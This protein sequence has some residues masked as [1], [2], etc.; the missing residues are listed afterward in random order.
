MWLI[1]GCSMASCVNFYMSYSKR[2]PTTWPVCQ[3]RRLRSA[4]ASAQSD[5]SLASAW[6]KL[7]SLPTH[8]AHTKDSGGCSGWSNSSKVAQVIFFFPFFF[9]YLDFTARQDYFTH[10]E[11]K[12]FQVGQKREVPEKKQQPDHPQSELGVSHIWPE[13]GSNPQL[14]DDKRF[15]VVKISGFNHSATGAAL[16]SFC[17]FCHALAHI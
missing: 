8:E 5:Q 15:R 3:A 9:F 14:W 16:M 6:K 2:K 17:W 7:R 13:L 4:L 1:Y 10:F 11:L 12:Q